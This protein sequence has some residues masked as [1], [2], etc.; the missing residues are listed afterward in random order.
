MTTSTQHALDIL[1]VE[2]FDDAVLLMRAFL[3]QSPHRLDVARHGQEGVEKV[4]NGRYDII[5]MDVQMPIMDGLSATR[6]IRAWETTEG[7]QPLPILAL[8]AHTQ[9]EDKQE[10]L[11]AGCDQCLTKPL[12]KATLLETLAAYTPT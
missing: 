5:L 1:L 8:T 3:K 4:Q 7:R 2:D 9:E 6:A 11:E 12:S 10:A